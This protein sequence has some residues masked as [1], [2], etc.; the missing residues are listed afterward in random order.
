MAE[1]RYTDLN[2]EGDI[3]LDEIREKHWR[4]VA[5]QGDNKKKIRDLRWEVYVKDN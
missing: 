2:E 4:D 5:E 1:E 3:R